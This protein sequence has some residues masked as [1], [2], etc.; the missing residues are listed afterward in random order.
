MGAIKGP[1]PY[2]KLYDKRPEADG[3]KSLLVALIGGAD[4]PLVA[5]P[6]SRS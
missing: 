3:E 2:P 6:R 5:L 4:T 1:E